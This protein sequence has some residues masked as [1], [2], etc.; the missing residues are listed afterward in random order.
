MRVHIPWSEPE[1]DFFRSRFLPTRDPAIAGWSTTVQRQCNE[2]TVADKELTIRAADIP[3]VAA[4]HK[5]LLTAE[6]PHSF[7]LH[8]LLQS[9]RICLV[10]EEGSELVAFVSARRTERGIHLL[11]LGVC[12]EFRRLRLGTHLVRAA[13]GALATGWLMPF[14]VVT[15]IMPPSPS[16]PPFYACYLLKSIQSP[17]S[18]ATYIGSTPNPPRRIRQHNGELTQGAYK[19]RNKRPWVMQMIEQTALQFEWAWQHVHRTRHLRDESGKALLSRATGLNNNIRA[20]RLMIGAHPYKT[21]PLH[22]KLFTEQAVKG[23]NTAQ[24]TTPPLP[25]GFTST[26]EL[27]GVDGRSGIAGTGRKVPIC[28]DDATFTSAHLAK[29]T[30]LLASGALIRCAVCR[31]EI[32]TYASDS[33]TTALC[34]ASGCSAVSHL[35]CLSQQF[36]RAAPSSSHI[37]PRGG[38]C[39]ECGTFV[40]WGDIIRGSVRRA[41][42]PQ[43]PELDDDVLFQPDSDAEADLVPAKAKTRKP[44]RKRPADAGDASSEGEEFD[45]AVVAEASGSDKPRQRGRP[46]KAA[47]SPPRK[48]DTARKRSL[49]ASSEGEEFDFAAVDAASG[50]DE[51]QKRSRPRKAAA[52]PPMK[53]AAS[54]AKKRGRPPSTSKKAESSGES[55]DLD[56]VSGSSEEKSPRKRVGRPRKQKVEASPPLEMDTSDLFE[57]DSEPLAG[58]MKALSVEVDASVVV[59]S[60]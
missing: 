53:K 5:Q 7:Y 30:A 49:N 57:S 9:D 6:Y 34:P 36:L 43:E 3:A 32:P 26:I 54:A 8:L 22:V 52:V 50:S 23:W 42:I 2:M 48:K 24:K 55:F 18:T 16:H 58:K 20:V 51:P 47:S 45:F 46:R 19:T 14:H 21:W 35:T 39:H 44:T 11:T 17:S 25:P 4:L 41:G 37:I 27:E 28:V 40:L 12:E 59:V 29:N 33:L 56:N 15:V 10:A 60:D 38:N 13:V 1:C 31:E